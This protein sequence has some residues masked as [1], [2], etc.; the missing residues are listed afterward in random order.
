MFHY[1]PSSLI[2]INQKL[3]RSQMYLYRGMNTENVVYLCNGVLYSSFLF[4]VL[5]LLFVFVFCFLGFFGGEGFETWFLCISLAVPWNSLCRP[6]CPQ[7]LKSACFCFPN[8]GMN[9][10]HHHAQLM[11]KCV[12]FFSCYTALKSNEF[13]KFLGKWMDLED[14]ILS[15]VTQLQKNLHMICTHC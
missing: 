12:L 9:G 1:V 10:V 8:A 2:Y 3:E 4:F 7:T 11:C 5:F 15:E 14:I 13:T 6:G